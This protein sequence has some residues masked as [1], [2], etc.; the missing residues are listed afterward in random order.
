MKVVIMAFFALLAVGCQVPRSTPRPIVYA[1]GDGSS[2][3]KAVVIRD[4]DCREVGT[5]AERLWL[6][7]SYPGYRDANQSALNL[8]NRRYHVV[9]FATVEG[10]T[11]KVYFD[12]TEVSDK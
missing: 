2:R 9:E 4:V 3:E 10:E 6:A 11:R 12:T 5:L 7:K 8:A 1:G